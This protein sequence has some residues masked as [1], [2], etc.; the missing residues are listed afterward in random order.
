MNQQLR[1]F[2]QNEGQREAIKEFFIECLKEMA[3]ERAFEG[4]GVVG[5]AEARELITKSFEKLNEMYGKIIETEISNS[6]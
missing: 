1:N 5:I 4:K 6:R 2:Y 3:V